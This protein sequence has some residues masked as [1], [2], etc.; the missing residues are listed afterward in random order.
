MHQSSRQQQTPQQKRRQQQQQEPPPLL[1]QGGASQPASA[2]AASGPSPAA[3]TALLT[4]RLT[5]AGSMSELMAA[6]QRHADSLRP[7]HIAAAISRAAKLCGASQAPVQQPD[8][9]AGLLASWL[10]PLLARLLAQL[11]AAGPAE[12]SCVV[13]GLARLSGPMMM[14]AR[15]SG[16]TRLVHEC[17]QACLGAS[18]PLL[19]EPAAGSDSSSSSSIIGFD[20]KLLMQLAWGAARLGVVPQQEWLDAFA[21]ATYER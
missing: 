10:Q 3:V 4:A 18:L 20:N 12:L 2:A 11:A 6:T 21:A 7:V 8:D 1:F 9:T 13:G 19:L 5:A 15:S 16:A 14:M 17:T